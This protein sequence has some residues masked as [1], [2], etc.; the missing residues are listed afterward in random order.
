MQ[1]HFATDKYLIANFAKSIFV[2]AFCAFYVSLCVAK[3]WCSFFATAK[4]AYA[5]FDKPSKS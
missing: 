4:I 1:N 5:D 2:V 3:F